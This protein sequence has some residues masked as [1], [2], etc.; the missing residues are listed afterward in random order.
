M[1]KIWMSDLDRFFITLRLQSVELT[2]IDIFGSTVCGRRNSCIYSFNPTILAKPLH[3]FPGAVSCLGIYGG[4]MLQRGLLKTQT[5]PTYL[6]STCVIMGF[7]SVI[8]SWVSLFSKSKEWFRFLLWSAAHLKRLSA[9]RTSI[10]VPMGGAKILSTM[11]IVPWRPFLSWAAIQAFSMQRFC[12][13]QSSSK[14]MV[15]CFTHGG[16][17]F[18]VSWM[19]D[20]VHVSCGKC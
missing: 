9:F 17:W 11:N 12:K 18:C 4:F 6:H 10:T 3:H 16:C 7:V 8:I 5:S 1:I 15:V 14:F 20:V 19:T 2:D 13:E